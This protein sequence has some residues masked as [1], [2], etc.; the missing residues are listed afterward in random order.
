MDIGKARLFGPRCRLW[1]WTGMGATLGILIVAMNFT[2]SRGGLVGWPAATSV[3]LRDMD[4]GGWYGLCRDPSRRHII[5]LRSKNGCWP[6]M[7]RTPSPMPVGNV[8]RRGRPDGRSSIRD[9]F[10]APQYTYPSYAFPVEGKLPDT[11]KSPTLPH[12]DYLQI[13]WRWA[14]R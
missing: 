2:Q 11:E 12:N 3:I 10:G 4:E 13:G 7:N 9:R 1:W 14:E 6:S 5:P 8:V